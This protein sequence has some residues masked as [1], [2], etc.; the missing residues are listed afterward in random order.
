MDEMNISTDDVDG[1]TD[2]YYKQQRVVIPEEWKKKGKQNWPKRVMAAMG[3]SWRGT[4][5][6]Y[7]VPSEVKMNQ[8]AFIKYVLQ[9]MVKKDFPG[10]YG[11]QASDEIL[12]MDNAV[13]HI[14]KTTVQ[15]LKKSCK[16][17]S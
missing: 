10:L 7:I 13:A 15:W 6:I 1:L 12:H 11:D 8:E 3:I 16:A 5:H 17:H 4:T 9:L 14:G 2:Y